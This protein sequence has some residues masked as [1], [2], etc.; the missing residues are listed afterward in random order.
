M[1]CYV[2]I[3]SYATTVV[4]LI[5][6][7]LLQILSEAAFQIGV[8]CMAK[9]FKY[10]AFYNEIKR[11]IVSE[12]Y[13]EGDMLSSE[14]QFME[15]YHISRIT[16]RS[17]LALLEQEGY[18]YRIQG[19]GCYVG[20]NYHQQ[21]LDKIH[22]YTDAILAAGMTPGRIVLSST[23]EACTKKQAA[24]LHLKE[25]EPVFI[26]KRIILADGDPICLT[27]AILPYARLIDIDRY[28]FSKESLYQILESKYG[29][30]VDRTAIT[31]EASS[32][33][34]YVSEM[35]SVTQNTPLL[36]Y[37]SVSYT[38]VGKDEQP[39][40]ICESF[41]LTNRMKFRLDKRR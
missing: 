22:S 39:F 35:L 12:E 7:I 4:N 40:E 25:Q 38:K 8:Y 31:L 37:D 11:K 18:I 36:I 26:L 27:K 24:L 10:L 21:S 20:G 1:A 9:D 33:D 2:I 41:Y 6:Y 14:T 16:V 15:K 23:V 19:K 29:Y 17:A 3:I 13:V 32:S 30:T 28:D 5:W 34:Q